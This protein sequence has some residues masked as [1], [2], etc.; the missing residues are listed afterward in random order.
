[1]CWVDLRVVLESE[2]E[3]AI[4]YIDWGNR[5]PHYANESALIEGYN[6]RN[7]LRNEQ[8]RE[9]NGTGEWVEW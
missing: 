7:H 3:A 8:K 5:S 6:L 9:V 4:T 1:M 2:L